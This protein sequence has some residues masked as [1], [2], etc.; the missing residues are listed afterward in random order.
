MEGIMKFIKN[1]A[2]DADDNP[3]TFENANIL[4]HRGLQ[5]GITAQL[6]ERGRKVAC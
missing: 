5:F 4:L 6:L 1:V 3:I 2:I